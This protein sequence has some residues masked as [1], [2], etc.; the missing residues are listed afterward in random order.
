MLA[1]P[2]S[3]QAVARQ[4]TGDSTGAWLAAAASSMLLDGREE[5]TLKMQVERPIVGRCRGG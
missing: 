4:Q 1:A 2:L 5:D 3:A